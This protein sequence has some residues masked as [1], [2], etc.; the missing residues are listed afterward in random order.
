MVPRREASYP[1]SPKPLAHP[2]R[3]VSVNIPE[4]PSRRSFEVKYHFAQYRTRKAFVAAMATPL[5]V[6]VSED[7]GLPGTCCIVGEVDRNG[8]SLVVAGPKNPFSWA[9]I[10]RINDGK[11]A[12]YPSNAGAAAKPLVEAAI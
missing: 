3:E 9:A 6:Y 8:G 11:I 5:D 10:V 7:S 12:V 2:G 1:G 4:M